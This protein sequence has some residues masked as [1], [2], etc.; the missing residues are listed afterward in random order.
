MEVN[1]QICKIYLNAMALCALMLETVISIVQVT[2]DL[3][4]TE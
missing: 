4:C 3:L 1:H 2:S